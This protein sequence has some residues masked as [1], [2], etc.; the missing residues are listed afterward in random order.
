MKVEEYNQIHEAQIVTFEGE[1][2]RYLRMLPPGAFIVQWCKSM[3]GDPY[4]G[5]ELV[6]DMDEHD[7]L[8]AAFQAVQPKELAS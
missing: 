4:W 7:R 5:F 8:E 1:E 2:N 6:V 3:H